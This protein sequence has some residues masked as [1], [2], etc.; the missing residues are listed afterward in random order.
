MAADPAAGR[1]RRE[2]AEA[3]LARIRKAHADAEAAD[4]AWAGIAEAPPYSILQ[5][6]CAVIDS[7]TG[8]SR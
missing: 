1:E 5:V 3:E 4:R 2:Y 7:Q 6:D 8:P